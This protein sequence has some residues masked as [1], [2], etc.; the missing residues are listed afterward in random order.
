MLSIDNKIE[1]LIDSRT[2]RDLTVE[3]YDKNI[4]LK[5]VRNEISEINFDSIKITTERYASHS[6]SM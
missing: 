5:K 4:V 6:L 1:K 2:R 3:A